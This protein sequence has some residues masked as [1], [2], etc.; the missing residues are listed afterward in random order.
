VQTDAVTRPDLDLGELRFL[1]IGVDD[2]DAA[3]APWLG[4]GAR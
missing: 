2:T 1:Y 4:M 3:L